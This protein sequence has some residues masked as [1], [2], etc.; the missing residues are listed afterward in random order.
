MQEMQVQP[1]DQEDPLEKE[2]ATH[3]SILAWEI[4]WAEE[5]DGLQFIGSQRVGHA[6][7]IKQQC[8]RTSRTAGIV[9]FSN[10]YFK[11]TFSVN[12]WR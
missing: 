2:M 6:L 1:L 9:Y 7:V 3:S 12:Q 8:G 4:L 5:P 10:F 11:N